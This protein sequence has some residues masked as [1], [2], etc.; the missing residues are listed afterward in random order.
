[1]FCNNKSS[2]GKYLFRWD[3]C[4]WN[5]EYFFTTL[6]TGSITPSLCLFFH[7]WSG[8][9]LS[10]RGQSLYSL[11]TRILLTVLFSPPL[12]CAFAFLTVSLWSRAEWSS[13]GHIWDFLRWL[14]KTWHF[15]DPNQEN[16]S[17][18]NCFFKNTL[19]WIY[20]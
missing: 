3:G 13:A 18:Q 16:S 20:Y 7:H 1:M 9:T 6:T 4:S 8:S 2:F 17:R 5:T 15:S 14:S 19:S 10:K 12:F 11:M